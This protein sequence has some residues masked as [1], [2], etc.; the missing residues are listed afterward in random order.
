MI[1]LLNEMMSTRWAPAKLLLLLPLLVSAQQHRA[2]RFSHVYSH[3]LPARVVG[4]GV[5]LQPAPFGTSPLLGDFSGDFG[6]LLTLAGFGGASSGPSGVGKS[7]L[8]GGFSPAPQ[9]TAYP[10]TIQPFGEFALSFLRFV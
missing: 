9:T 6:R 3:G 4:G 5:A 1:L 8:V 7:P 10:G 2:A